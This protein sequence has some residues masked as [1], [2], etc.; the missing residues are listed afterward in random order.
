MTVLVVAIPSTALVLPSIR[1]GDD[2]AIHGMRDEVA[3]VLADVA[4]VVVVLATDPAAVD[5]AVCL[6]PP[7]GDVHLGG[8]GLP[9]V[10]ARVS[11]R[12]P[13]LP[14]VD[15]HPG[16]DLS[17]LACAVGRL[18]AVRS[19]IAVGVPSSG[20]GVDGVAGWVRSMAD[21]DALVVAGDLSAGHGPKPPRPSVGEQRAAAYDHAVVA[22]VRAGVLEPELV[23][24]AE[25]AAARGVPALAVAVALAGP[26]E[27]VTH[28]VVDG[29]GSLVAR[30]P[31]P[32]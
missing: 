28:Q 21:V 32:A 13:G 4:G 25:E 22:G 2:P 7:G 20:A 18:D 5:G 6:H 19:V 3:R 9:E 17:V 16:A 12:P 1:T 14:G 27:R 11:G 24:D 10:A 23:G 31:T 29:V 8:L 15:V 30:W 26:A